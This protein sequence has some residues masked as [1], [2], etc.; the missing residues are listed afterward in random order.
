MS[1]TRSVITLGS[2]DGVHL[3]HHAILNRVVRLAR[4]HRARATALVFERPPRLVRLDA[5]APH[6]LTS[7]SEKKS[8]LKAIGIQRVDPLRFDRKTS[9]LTPEQFFERIIVRKH[10]A[11]AMVVGPRFAFGHNRTGTLTVLKTLAQS[12]GIDVHVVPMVRPGRQ[13][14]SSSQIRECLLAGRTAQASRALGY[15]YSVSGHVIH[16]AHRGRKLGFPTLNIGIPAG[17]ILPLGVYRVKVQGPGRTVWNG[18][19]NVGNRPTFQ[20]GS[21]KLSVEVFVLSHRLPAMYGKQ[22]TVSFYERLRGEKR[23]ASPQ[24]LVAQIH[25]DVAR[26]KRLI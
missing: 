4:K 12:H 19:C 1:R 14:V 17:K 25:R 5:A 6:L 16:G 7:W 2:F 3:G 10:A 23:F 13:S 15:T 8:R 26:A 22:V 24:A 11:R 9:F 20:P 18:L 21:R